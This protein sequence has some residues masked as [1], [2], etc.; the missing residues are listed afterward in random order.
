MSDNNIDVYL[1]MEENVTTQMPGV[2]N[3]LMASKSAVRELAMGTSYLGSAM[4]GMSIAMRNSNNAALQGA[5]NMLGMVGGI[6]TAVGSAAHF[7]SAIAKMTSALQKFNIAQAIANALSGPL[8]WAKLAVGIGV[9]GA[10]AYGI[11]K[12]VGGMGGGG[13]GSTTVV[14]QYV[15]GSV[16]TQRELTDEMHGGLLIKQSRSASTGIR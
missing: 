9:A 13:Q 14:N 16:V 8:G 5:S 4:L 12:M 6:M 15:Q 7:V 1:S 11:T 10:A 3:S 2:T